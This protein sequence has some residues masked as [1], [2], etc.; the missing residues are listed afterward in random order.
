[1]TKKQSTKKQPAAK[2]TLVK[3]MLAKK[4]PAKKTPKP[5]KAFPELDNYLFN[6]AANKKLGLDHCLDMTLNMYCYEL[7]DEHDD[8]KKE[9]KLVLGADRVDEIV[10]LGT[11]KGLVGFDASVATSMLRAIMDSERYESIDE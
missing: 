6:A 9:A 4:T 10:A 1:M 7:P 5:K 3:K 8:L 2:K 11:M